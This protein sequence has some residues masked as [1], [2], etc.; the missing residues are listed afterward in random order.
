MSI[1]GRSCLLLIL[2]LL[3]ISPCRLSSASERLTDTQ[4]LH[5]VYSMYEDYKK[6]FPAVED[7]TPT[8]AMALMT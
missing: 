2:L 3:A 1:H 8:E 4:K 6:K 5:T 7:I